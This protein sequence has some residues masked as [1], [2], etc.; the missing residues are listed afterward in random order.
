[1]IEV[2]AL[3][4]RYGSTTAVDDVSFNIGRGEIVG[5]LGHNGAGKTTIMRMLSGYLEPSAG[6]IEIAG[7]PLAGNAHVIQ[8]QLG[9]LPEN[10]PVYPD[11]IVADYLDYV[12]TLKGIERAERMGAVRAVLVA[13]DLVGRAL[14]P[15][16]NLSRGLKQRVGVAQAI[17]GRPGLLI[18]DEPTNGLDP[19]QTAHMRELIRQIARRA[20]I[21]LSTHIM[22]EVD[23]VCD[24]VLILRNGRLALDR[25]LSELRESHSLL[26]RTD[27]MTD[28]LA[29]DIRD[30]AQVAALE[31]DASR[32]DGVSCHVL[33]HEAV[34][35][36]IA[37]S[38]IASVVVQSGARLY[39]LTP[40][41]R[42]LDTV[43]REATID[44]A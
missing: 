30:V 19:H 10:L 35:M 12:A 20:T 13:T 37:A 24:R 1:M 21:I 36:D 33:L 8:Q 40:V 4:R 22:Q 38:A 44:G 32:E 7:L 42:D 6:S 27:S 31:P 15:I 5:L 23:A 17:L 25:K 34:D 9:Y 3:T 16:R 11:M 26:L 39:Q 29:T 14:E 18:L 43:F 41:S 2:R 28:Q